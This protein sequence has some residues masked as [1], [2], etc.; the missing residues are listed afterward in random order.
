MRTQRKDKE[1]AMSKMTTSA[2]ALICLAAMAFAVNSTAHDTSAKDTSSK[3]VLA[4]D[5]MFGVDGAFVGETNPIRGVI[6]DELP[7]EVAQVHGRLDRKGHLT[8]MVRGLVF[9]ND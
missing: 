1:R 6:G 3:S 9:K 2:M 7:W 8:I 4:F 5:N